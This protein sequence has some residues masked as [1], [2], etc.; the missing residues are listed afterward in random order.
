M[1]KIVYF[2]FI[3]SFAVVMFSGVEKSAGPPGCHAGEAPNFFNCTACHTDFPVN[4]GSA[5]I[6]FDLSGADTGYIPGHTY[7]INISLKKTGMLA[8]GFQFIA[9]QNNSLSVSP[10][11]ITLTNPV[12]TQKVD[13]SNP[14]VQGCTLQQKVWVEHTFQGILSDAFGESLWSFKWKAP[15][16]PVG[17][18]TF[19]LAALQTNYN[20]DEFG[21]YV[22]TRSLTA[23]SVGVGIKELQNPY[24]DLMIFPNPATSKL[25]VRSN[26]SIPI[27][28]IELLNLYGKSI[29]Q[30]ENITESNDKD[31]LIDLTG[32]NS[33]VYFAVING[34]GILTVKK[35]MIQ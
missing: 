18:I 8:A 24:A 31:I 34:K 33:G 28:K 14:H 4:T 10:G 1:K 23:N 12:R 19:Y 26:S 5:T 3:I 35:I 16:V 25:I 2:L 22:Y 21:D 29:K 27:Q 32:I 6:T 11:T 20:G 30:F 17:N 7:D 13:P 9:L 15:D